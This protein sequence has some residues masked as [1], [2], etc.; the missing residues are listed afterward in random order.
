MAKLPMRKSESVY[1]EI[2]AKVEHRGIRLNASDAA[3]CY[4]LG[5]K[6]L[7]KYY[8]KEGLLAETAVPWQMRK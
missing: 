8:L 3:R 2:S 5:I 1:I 7:R 4:H 6:V